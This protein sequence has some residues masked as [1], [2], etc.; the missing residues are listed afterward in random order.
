VPRP[1]SLKSIWKQVPADYYEQPNFFQKLWQR[2]KMT[3]VKNL[4]S[5]V[6]NFQQVL[7]IGCDGGTQTAILASYFPGA[8]FTG[9]DVF[10]SAVS[11]AHRRYPNIRF[12]QADAHQLP[13]TN[14]SFDLILCLETLEHLANP[15]GVLEETKRCLKKNGSVIIEI[16]SGNLLFC[17]VWFFWIRT[18]GK[19]WKGAHL[20]KFNPKKLETLFSKHRLEVKSKKGFNFKMGVAYRLQKVN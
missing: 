4:I 5:E 15:G 7:D 13:F 9:L 16:D 11:F 8:E 10:P 6:S 17:L 19:V 12:L 2:G 3:V 1:K 14:Q 18:F 20:W